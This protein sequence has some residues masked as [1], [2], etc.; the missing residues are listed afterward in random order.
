MAAM[1]FPAERSPNTLAGF[2]W[3]L[4]GRGREEKGKKGREKEKKE[5]DARD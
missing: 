4:W 1:L 5:R 3:L 2:E